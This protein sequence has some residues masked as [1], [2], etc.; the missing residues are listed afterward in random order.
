MNEYVSLHT[1]THY[2][3]LDGH[4][5]V[6]EYLDYAK[7][8]GM[9][10]LGV[11]DHGNVSSVYELLNE[12][13]K[14][15]MIGVPGCEFYAAPQ[16]KLGAKVRE[17]VFYGRNGRERGDVSARGA[18]THQTIFAVNNKGLKNLFKLSTM[19]NDPEHFYQ[20]PRIDFEMLADHSEGLVV[21]TGCPSS[22]ISTRFL[23]DQD[24]EAY[25]YAGRMKEVFGDRM[26]VEV[27]NHGLDIES[28]LIPKQLELAKKLGLELLASTDAHY[29]EKSNAKAHEEMLCSQSQAKMTDKTWDE[30]GPRFAFADDEYYI[31]SYDEMG[32]IFD[33]ESF[34]RALSNTLLI[35]EMAQDIVFD[36]DPHLKPKPNIPDGFKTNVEYYKKLLEEGFKMRYGN[37][38]KH[39]QE[40]AREMINYEFDVIYSSDFIGYM[41][42]VTDY[43]RWVKEK[44]STRDDDGNIVALSIG[45]GRGSV[46]GSIHAYL[47]GI[48][49]LC[50]IRYDLV[51]ERFLSPGRGETYEIEYDD[52]T[53]EQILV[54]EKVK[55]ASGGNEK[56]IHELNPGDEVVR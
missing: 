13:K 5:K 29:V 6:N 22:E 19:S 35:A 17:P 43:L 53:R 1:H 12:A 23:L 21:A 34:P 44:Y 15:D 8:L 47:L 9:K 42:T 49:E 14:R 54:S 55:M 41:L 46:G 30:G 52:G 37:S 16:N 33:N 48:S 2:S 20:A 50:P 3:L 11:A 25:D 27:M 31:K 36:Y 7:N 45:V 24:K 28:K 32:K 10:A 26:F 56:Y 39:I 38:P 51:F 4:G 40:K 18:Y